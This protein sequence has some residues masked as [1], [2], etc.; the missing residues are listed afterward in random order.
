MEYTKGE[1][2]V[3]TGRFQSG[4]SYYLNR[5]YVA[6]Y[7]WNSTRSQ[8][9]EHDNNDWLGAVALPSLKNNTVVAGSEQEIKEKIEHIVS[10]WFRQALAKAEGK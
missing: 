4:A 2:R 7:E 6:G 5:I 9:R 10:S 3:K 8:P 1:W